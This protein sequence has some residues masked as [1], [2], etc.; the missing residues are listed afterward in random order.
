MTSIVR[1][2]HI[3]YQ[4]QIHLNVALWIMHENYAS[5]PET[6]TRLMLTCYTST[7]QN[8]MASICQWN[9]YNV[10]IR[11]SGKNRYIFHNFCVLVL[12]QWKTRR[13]LHAR[14]ISNV[15]IMPYV[16]LFMTS[17]L[18][19]RCVYLSM[20]PFTSKSFIAFQ[21]YVS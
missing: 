11:K 14:K 12:S 13:R 4:S 7:W 17:C 3:K 16:S 20:S 2:I 15:D 18:L 19:T 1:L 5:Y 8:E 21:L 6:Y 10:K 9:V